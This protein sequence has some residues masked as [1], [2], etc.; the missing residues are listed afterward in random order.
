MASAW[1]FGERVF[2]H[3]SPPSPP[4]PSWRVG[5]S[6]GGGSPQPAAQ[7]DAPPTPTERALQAQIVRLEKENKEARE[8]HQKAL[9]TVVDGN[10]SALKEVT[11]AWG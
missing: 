6:G 10:K 4:R 8:Y 11:A 1:M 9:N 3:S 5:Q 2:E 7:L